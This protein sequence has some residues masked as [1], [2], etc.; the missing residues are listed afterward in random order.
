LTFSTDDTERLD[1]ARA[2]LKAVE[3]CSNTERADA[4]LGWAVELLGPLADAGNPAAVW[5][6]SDAKSQFSDVKI[7]PDVAAEQ[8]LAALLAA[9]N[10]GVPK[11]QFLASLHF[12]DNGDKRQSF[13]LCAQAA[14]SG[15]AY[16][17]WCH[18]LDLI[19]GAGG[20]TDEQKGLKFIERAATKKFEGAI[21]F[22]ADALAIGQHGF[23][24]DNAKAAKWHRML[25]AQ[26]VIRY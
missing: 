1:E 21:R 25:S 20:P 2:L 7:D 16:A 15:H 24:V 8:H 5:I 10:K 11:A 13:A 6:L 22:M 18:G 19:S 3:Q 23:T 26:D 12:F 14:A 17:M 4:M 9:A